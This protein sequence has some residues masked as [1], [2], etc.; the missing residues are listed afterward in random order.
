MHGHC[1][2]TTFNDA[3]IPE[4]AIF[5]S[6]SLKR[7]GVTLKARGGLY[8]E[9]WRDVEACGGKVFKLSICQKAKV[10]GFPTRARAK[11]KGKTACSKPHAVVPIFRPFSHF[12]FAFF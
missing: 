11:S 9:A 7:S 5:G 12:H 2:H 10:T 6:F 4:T 8:V 3:F 1:G